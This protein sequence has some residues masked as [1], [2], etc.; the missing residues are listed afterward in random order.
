MAASG[1][2]WE[3]GGGAVGGGDGGRERPGGRAQGRAGAAASPARGAGPSG[4]IC[5]QRELAGTRRGQRMPRAQSR[6]RHSRTRSAVVFSPTFHPTVEDPDIFVVP[7]LVFLSSSAA[8]VILKGV[9][10]GRKSTARL[11]ETQ[12]RP[13]A[14]GR[15]GFFVHTQ[16]LAPPVWWLGTPRSLPVGTQR[17]AAVPTACRCPWEVSGALHMF[18]V[19]SLSLSFRPRGHRR[20]REE[21]QM[22]RQRLRVER[23][24]GV[25]TVGDKLVTEGQIVS[26]A[27]YP[28]SPQQSKPQRQQEVARG[29]GSGH[30]TVWLPGD[31][32][33]ALQDEACLGHGRR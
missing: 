20:G 15:A 8:R 18:L 10:T 22:A 9:R 12:R 31:T 13:S 28:R 14:G 4:H 21:K 7:A 2:L 25:D 27:T 19:E 5:P 30:G 24:S 6:E 11:T 23:G 3:A 16:G 33:L 1:Q 26:D 32:A 29:R 17:R